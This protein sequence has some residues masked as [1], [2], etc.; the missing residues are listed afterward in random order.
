MNK[1]SDSE[2][3]KSIKRVKRSPKLGLIYEIYRKEQEL[4]LCTNTL[5]RQNKVWIK[6]LAPIQD[7]R[8]DR[9]EPLYIQQ[10]ILKPIF[11]EKK[12]STCIYVARLLTV[13]LDFSVVCN[14]IS[15]NPVKEIFTLPLLK[16][17]AQQQ[18][19]MKEHRA[20]LPYDRLRTELMQVIKCFH[21]NTGI[22]RQ[23][24]LEIS[25]RTILRPRE[26]TSLKISDLDTEKHTLTVYNTK[27]LAKFVIP[28][29]KRLEKALIQAHSNYG[30]TTHNWVFSGI[31]KKDQPLSS[32]SLN[33]A[34]KDL[35]YKDKLCAH[36]IRSIA[37][38]F[39]AAH[40]DKIHP[41]T[42]EAMLQHSVGTAVARAYRRDSYFAERVKAGQIWN[43]WL[44][45][46][47]RQLKIDID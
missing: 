3:L 24:L 5:N 1:T 4:T 41:W 26:V 25:L 27:T 46:I 8:I 29:S 17:A 20:T 43:E 37:S 30:S 13:L 44:D 7:M 34:L 15:I 32:Q 28:T 47:Y 31:K 21:N 2:F 16:R 42:A 6:H 38:N 45:G 40:S 22:R 39:F 35:G 18:T 10:R 12:Y 33:R 11:I 14:I 36:G 23:L 9:M 19:K